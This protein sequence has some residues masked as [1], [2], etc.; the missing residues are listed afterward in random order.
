MTQRTK[1]VAACSGNTILGVGKT[2]TWVDWWL[3]LVQG[4]CQPAWGSMGVW[5]VRALTLGILGLIGCS[6]AGAA[7]VAGGYR[8]S[9]SRVYLQ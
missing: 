7:T 8:R 3:T 4:V 5:E 9:T 1:S 6:V 2:A